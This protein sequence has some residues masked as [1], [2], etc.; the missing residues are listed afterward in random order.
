MYVRPKNPTKDRPWRFERE[1]KV[2]IAQLFGQ[3]PRKGKQRRT[4]ADDAVLAVIESQHYRK[5]KAEFEAFYAVGE[6]G[7]QYGRPAA[8]AEALEAAPA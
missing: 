8:A 3:A 1:L 5:R 2:W 4:K 7:G 6:N